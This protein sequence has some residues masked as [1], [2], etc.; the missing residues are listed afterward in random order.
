MRIR[1]KLINITPAL[2]SPDPCS[3]P[4]PSGSALGLSVGLLKGL[5]QSSG[6]PI[7]AFLA[8]EVQL[9]SSLCTVL[10]SSRPKGIDPE[11]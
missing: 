1:I 8:L 7:E 5:V 4:H 9:S 2:I 3:L 6:G 10:F 11:R